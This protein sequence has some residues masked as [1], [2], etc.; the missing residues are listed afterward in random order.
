MAYVS[1]I[2]SSLEYGATVWDPYHVGDINKIERIQRQAARFIK[3]DYRSHEAGCVSEMLRELKLPP[4]EERRKQQRLTT[5]YK[6]VNEEIPALPPE[7]FLTKANKEKR[8]IKPRMFEGFETKNI[9]KKY[10]YNNTKGFLVPDSRTE[11]YKSSFFVRTVA[12][13]NELEEEVVQ[14]NSAAAFSA[15]LSRR[16]ARTLP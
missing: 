2:R 3:R 13:W 15:A 1:L 11:Q 4:L 7:K 8:K 6:I 12:E 10:A 16:A 5:M 14:A 9:V